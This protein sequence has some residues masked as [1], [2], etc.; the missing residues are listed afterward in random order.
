M[1]PDDK[2]ELLDQ[3]LGKLE[4]GDPVDDTAIYALMH[5]AC[6]NRQAEG[7]KLE[8]RPQASVATESQLPLLAPFGFK[9]GRL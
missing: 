6:R 7:G 9:G 8:R 5:R 1:H 3:L 2:D 4:R